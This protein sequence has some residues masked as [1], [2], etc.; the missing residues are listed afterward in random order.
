MQQIQ[1]LI[2]N[3]KTSSAGIAAALMALADLIHPGS[4]VPD[5]KADIF[6]ISLAVGL[7]FG[8]DA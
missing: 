2:D 8:K 6:A 1:K 3:W 5:I 7:I 4:G